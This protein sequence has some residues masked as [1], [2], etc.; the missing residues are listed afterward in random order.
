M[1][2]LNKTLQKSKENFDICFSQSKYIPL[3]AIFAFF[4]KKANIKLLI[5]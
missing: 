3:I 1:H 4:I 2:V 5:F